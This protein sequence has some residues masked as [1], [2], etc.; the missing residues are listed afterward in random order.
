[1]ALIAAIVVVLGFFAVNVI[2]QHYA[3]VIDSM[4]DTL[5]IKA[6]PSISH[7]AAAR[8]ARRTASVAG[9]GLIRDPPADWPRDRAA[10]VKARNLLDQE[11]AAYVELPSFPGERGQAL[12]A[13]KDLGIFE[14]LIDALIARADAGVREPEPVQRAE[15]LTQ[16]SDRADEDLESLV[17]FNADR[18]TSTSLGIQRAR[19]R[20]AQLSYVLHLFAGALALLVLWVVGRARR[21]YERVVEARAQLE[22]ERKQMAERRAA[23]LDMFAARVAHDL[24]NPLSAIAIAMQLADRQAEDP[25]KVRAGVARGRRAVERMQQ[26]ID[27]L[28]AFAR[29]AGDQSHSRESTDLGE[30]LKSAFADLAPLAEDAGADISLGPVPD[31]KVACAAGPLMSVLCNL[32]GNAVKYIVAVPQESRHIQVRAREEHGVVRVEIE[33]SGPG[34]PLE[35]QQEIFE[36]YVRAP[37][38]TQPGL[39]LGLA[40]VKRIVEGQGGKVGVRSSVGEGSCF[41]FELARAEEPAED[42][43]HGQLH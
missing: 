14:K 33:D 18:A 2:S 34:I 16:A 23:E 9:R 30:A 37:G 42:S 22:S 1:L 13:A 5:E 36:P 24:K 41:W 29:A 19:A 28:L 6:M 3:L 27:G 15:E 26:I 21:S 17:R 38:A 35:V 20:A 4:A 43:A 11:M 8:G 10:L 39:G 7:L 31:V 25:D 32:L 40:T 12:L